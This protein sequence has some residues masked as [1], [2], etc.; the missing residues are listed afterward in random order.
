MQKVILLQLYVGK[1]LGGLG[2]GGGG[3][4]SWRVWG[5]GL[6]E[7]LGGGGGVV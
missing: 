1:T 4:R 7:T 3:G 5:G 2:R 6:Y